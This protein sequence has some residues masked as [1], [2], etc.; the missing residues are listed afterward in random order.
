MFSVFVAV[1][2]EDLNHHGSAYDPLMPD[3]E[4]LKTGLLGTD[5]TFKKLNRTHMEV[6]MNLR[7]VERESKVPRSAA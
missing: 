1:F 7:C 3:S 6:E 5:A 2:Q 4:N